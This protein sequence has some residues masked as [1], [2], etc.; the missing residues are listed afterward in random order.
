MSGTRRYRA[1]VGN[2]KRFADDLTA[3]EALRTLTARFATEVG[4]DC[5]TVWSAAGGD[6]AHVFRLPKR[7]CLLIIG[8]APVAVEMRDLLS[9]GAVPSWTACD[10][11]ETRTPLSR[12]ID[13]LPASDRRFANILD[14][15]GYTTVEEVEAT[16]MQCLAQVRH[17]GTTF[18]E[19]IEACLADPALRRPAVDDAIARRLGRLQRRIDPVRGLRNATMLGLLA[20][21][22]LTDSSVDRIVDS[23]SGES[24]PA[25][26]P[27]VAMLLTTADDPGPLEHYLA[28]HA[29]DGLAR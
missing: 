15:I 4:T 1:R 20:R 29:A 22:A 26:D 6:G 3:A 24:V 17:V 18:L 13:C 23:L 9:S 12:L 14:R 2:G 11:S 25:V 10:V 27:V 21:S 7:R 8:D 28:T 19:A 16:P 5:A